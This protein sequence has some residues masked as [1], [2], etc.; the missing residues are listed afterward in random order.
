LK[1]SRSFA[2]DNN[3]GIHPEILASIVAANKGHVVSYGNDPYT[4]AAIDKFRQHFGESIDVYFVFGG[5]AANVIALQ[6]VNQ[7]YN[8]VVCAEMAHINTDECGAPEKFTGCKLLTIPAT[9]GKIAVRK[10]EH[11]LHGL[12]DQHH[13]QPKVISISQSTEMG[14]V[15]TPLEIETLADF[16]H[17]NQMF[18]HMDGARLSNAAVS[19]NVPLK[20]ITADVGVDV[21]SFGGTKNGMLVG[22]SIVFFDPLI[23]RN[24]KFIRK[25][26]M[27]L[28]P[29][30]RFIA[31]QFDALLSKDLWRRNAERANQM[32]IRLAQEVEKIP[33]IKITQKVQANGVFAIVPR[34]SIPLL[35]EEYFFYVWNEEVSEVRWMTSFDT[36]EEDVENFVRLL[37]E[38]VR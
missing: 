24:V 30:M 5:T 13:V 15:Y 27:Q 29:K 25:Q 28:A 7:S 12:G 21:L 18:L 38:K 31:A 34:R 3:A 17:Q 37:R 36:T 26:G 32:A 20:A 14:T 11:H 35:Q 8:A 9:D 16:A 22:E 23:S 4:K 2:S 19:L 1:P 33:G 6:A 10:I